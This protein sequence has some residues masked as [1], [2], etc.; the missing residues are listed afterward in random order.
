MEDLGD[1]KEH[2]NCKILKSEEVWNHFRQDNA[3]A[4]GILYDRYVDDL[5][6]YGQ[7]ITKDQELIKDC[8]QDLFVDIW[9]KRKKFP[10]VHS[11]KFYLFKGLKRKIIRKLIRNRKLPIDKNILEEY[12]FEIIFSCES[13][14]ITRQISEHQQKQ[15]LQSL[16]KL[17]RRQKEAITLKFLDEFSYKEV[18]AILSMSVKSTYHLI[19]RA[20]GKLKENFP[21][22]ITFI[23]LNSP[24]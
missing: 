1:H 21:K 10:E 16:N 12:N 17:P 8:I 24:F 2:K 11:M 22:V 3:K 4:L 18:A 5:Y 7:R 20:L 15:L 19:Y 6:H 9:E 14:L 23:L 13:E